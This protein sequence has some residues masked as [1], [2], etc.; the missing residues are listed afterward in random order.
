MNFFVIFDTLSE[1]ISGVTNR[2]YHFQLADLIA[3]LT[4]QS[5]FE[6]SNWIQDFFLSSKEWFQRQQ[7]CNFTERCCN[8]FGRTTVSNHCCSQMWLFKGEISNTDTGVLYTVWD[9]TW[10]MKQN[11]ILIQI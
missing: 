4:H 7:D 11:T 6:D 10:N 9:T 2:Q 3:I 5:C 1:L 8:N